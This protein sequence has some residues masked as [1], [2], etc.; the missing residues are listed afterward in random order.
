[1][2][3]VATRARGVEAVLGAAAFLESGDD[4]LCGAQALAELALAE[5]RLGAQVVDELSEGEV[6]LTLPSIGAGSYESAHLRG[7]E[8]FGVVPSRCIDRP[9]VCDLATCDSKHRESRSLL[10]GAG[11]T[12]I[13]P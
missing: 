3:A 10:A 8:T 2:R 7:S 4:R 11:L 13:D 5:A 9:Q 6:L 12:W 1:M